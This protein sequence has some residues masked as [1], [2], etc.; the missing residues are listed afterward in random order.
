MTTSSLLN[1]CEV[2]DRISMGGQPTIDQFSVIKQMGKDVIIQLVVKEASYS[3]KDEAYH[4]DKASLGYEFMDI[5]F[6]NPT[7]EDVEQFMQ[8]MQK[9][10]DKN[11]YV[12]CAVG[13]CTS[14]LMVIYLMQ[15]QSMTYAEAKA[16]VL[17]DWNPTPVWT[18]LIEETTGISSSN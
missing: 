11:L 10:R 17:S 4:V 5:S 18:N 14:G 2:T 16:C 9:Y 3:V 6:A 15:T 13:F 12:H 8:L 1:Y 7:L